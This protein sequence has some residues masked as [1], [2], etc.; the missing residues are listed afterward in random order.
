MIRMLLFAAL[1]L[2]RATPVMPFQMD[3]PKW[4]IPKG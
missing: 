4:M 1:P 2:L 3:D